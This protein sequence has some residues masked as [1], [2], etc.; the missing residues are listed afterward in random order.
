MQIVTPFNGVCSKT[1][2]NRLKFL[3]DL[4]QD[5]LFANSPD[6]SAVNLQ[7]FLPTISSAQLKF[8][9]NFFKLNISN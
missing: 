1:F 7:V 3:V 4:C 9:L 2:L 6:I 5:R 8:K